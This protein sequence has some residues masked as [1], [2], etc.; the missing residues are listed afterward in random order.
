MAWLV[1]PRALA[2]RWGQ[3]QRRGPLPL[4]WGCG[5]GGSCAERVVHAGSPCAEHASRSHGGGG[6]LHEVSRGACKHASTIYKMQMQIKI[7]FWFY[8]L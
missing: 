4:R 5:S 3:A 6:V 2:E 7:R 8:T 1:L